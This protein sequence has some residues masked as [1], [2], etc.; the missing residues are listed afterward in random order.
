MRRSGSRRWN[1]NR[2]LK[3]LVADLSLNQEVLK[4]VMRKR[5]DETVAALPTVQDALLAA[6][7][8]LV[9]A[10]E[11]AQGSRSLENESYP[12][13]EI[14]AQLDRRIG[15]LKPGRGV[16]TEGWFRSY[17]TPMRG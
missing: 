12:I 6:R 10:K 1:E 13:A 8:A 9:V 17:P 16:S 4:A 3:H 7:R 5:L 14:L 2:R 15:A 11:H